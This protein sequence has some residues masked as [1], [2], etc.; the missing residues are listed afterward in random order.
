MS[1]KR[2]YIGKD[3]KL[4][5]KTKKNQ[6]ITSDIE[7]IKLLEDENVKM[8]QKIVDLENQLKEASNKLLRNAAETENAKKIIKKETDQIVEYANLKFIKELINVMD[9]FDRAIE[10]LEKTEEKNKIIE[11]IKMIDKQ[12]HQFFEKF[13][14]ISYSAEGAQFDPQVH[15]A[16]SAMND[17]SKKDGVVINEF[18][19]G[20]KMNERVIRPAKVIVNKID[21]NELND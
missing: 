4:I 9:N 13:N 17:R 11:G 7:G 19:K 3:I 18:A 5:D 12:F 6:E 10:A 21:I 16:I 8:N 14:V 2:K 1:K 15:E 20:Y